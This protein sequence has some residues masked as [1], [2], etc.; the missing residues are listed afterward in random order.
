[1]T[2][3][4]TDANPVQPAPDRLGLRRRVG[5]PCR[6]PD[7]RPRD[8]RAPATAR[9]P[10]SWGPFSDAMFAVDLETGALRWIYQPHPSNRDDLDFAGA[11][12]LIDLDG[13]KLAGLGNK[14][15]S[16][17]LVDRDDG[18]A[19][20]RGRGDRS[21][22]STVPAATSRPVA[23]SG[24]R[25]TTTGSSSAAPRS[26][27]RRTCTASTLRPAPSRG[28]TR[29]RARPTPR[30]RSPATSRSSAAPTSRLRAVAVDSGTELW[31]HAMKGAVAGG[32]AITREDVFAVAGI[33]EP[34]LDKRSRSSGVYRFS[35]HGKRAQIQ[36]K[37]PTPS[38]TAASSEPQECVGSPCDLGFDLKKPPA[39]LTPTA[40]LEITRSRSS[41][42]SRPTGSVRPRDG[43]EPGPRPR[44]K[45]ATNYAVFL[46]ESDDN[47]T[48]GLV[49][50]LDAQLE[51]TGR[52][53]P[54]PGRDLQPGDARRGEGH[55]D[56]PIARR[57]LRA[58][59]HHRL[60]RSTTP[61]PPRSEDLVMRRLVLT[62]LTVTMLA[63][64]GRTR[65][66]RARAGQA[67]RRSGDR[68][69]R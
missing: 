10:T 41:S 30:P 59:R 1:M 61:A 65:G 67:R 57:R 58:P 33:R 55:E 56:A 68:L 64:A 24:R 50:I 15:G 28:R 6:R 31:S 34:G 60:V 39:G 20:L 23:S 9:P 26:G 17:Y 2:A 49:C 52:P 38:S 5:L 40:R 21:P 66:G 44:P 19:R 27:R 42:T 47:P 7:P 53:S 48:G 43:S 45:G 63:A 8:R 54:A 4:S 36:I 12:N 62:A 46:S 11:P 37:Q 13:R 32:A 22:G 14:D 51:C 69:Q 16:Y 3:P 29:S 18:R 25:R 35:L